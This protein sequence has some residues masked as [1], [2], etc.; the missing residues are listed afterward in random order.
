MQY[1]GKLQMNYF[2]SRGSKKMLLKATNTGT[3]DQEGRFLKNNFVTFEQFLKTV[4]W[5]DNNNVR[6]EIVKCF[7][8]GSQCLIVFNVL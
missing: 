5:Y 7:T 4:R 1:N 2:F 6:F 8:G 3:Y